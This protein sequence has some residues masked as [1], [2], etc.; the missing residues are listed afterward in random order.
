[1]YINDLTIY[2]NEHQYMIHEKDSYEY[3]KSYTHEYLF[4]Q[5]MSY[6]QDKNLFP[7]IRST[8]K[9]LNIVVLLLLK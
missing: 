2:E 9:R 7:N 8:D 4:N 3:E 6:C 1:M 5:I